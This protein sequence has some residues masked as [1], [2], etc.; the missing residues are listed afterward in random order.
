MMRLKFL[1]SIADAVG[2]GIE[3]GQIMDLP[4]DVAKAWLKRRRG[5]PG[6]EEPLCVLIQSQ[7]CPKC[8]HELQEPTTEELLQ[9]ATVNHAPKRRG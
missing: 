4:D 2:P 5:D 8:G 6:A 7:T 9:A 1:T 3:I